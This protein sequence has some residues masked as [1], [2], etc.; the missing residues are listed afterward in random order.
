MIIYPKIAEQLRI[1]VTAPSS[2]VSEEYHHYFDKLKQK[3][4]KNQWLLTIGETASLQ[5]RVRSTDAETRA[6]ELNHFLQED[7]I[8]CIIPPWGGELL[9]EVLPLIEY[10]KM[11]PKWILGY[12]DISSLLFALTL[13]TG[14]ATAHG[15]NAVELR[16]EPLDQTTAQWEQVLRTSL[17]G[18]IQQFSSS[19][20]QEAWDYNRDTFALTKKT[21]W[22]PLGDYDYPLEGRLLGGCIDI[23][24][25]LIGTEYGDV[26]QF[27]ADLQE[28]P[29][30]WYLENCE[31][32]PVDLKRSLLQMKMAG[33]FDNCAGILFGRTEMKEAQQGYTVAEVHQEMAELLKVPVITEIDCGH[34]P[35][36]LTFINGVRGRVFAKGD[37]WVLEQEFVE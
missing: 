15:P 3:A 36:Q 16:G 18:T 26:R 11:Q 35:P 4:V 13:K 6:R 19:K 21:Q 9:L 30:L 37:Q 25:H 29:I 8:N 23:L 20:Y 31:L 22:Q 27:Q 28:E 2:G 7:S 14:I 10:E 34:V 24:R 5:D 12:S 32:L 1:A 33:W 17:G